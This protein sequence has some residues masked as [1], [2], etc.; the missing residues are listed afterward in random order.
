M[1]NY[2]SCSKFADWVRGTPKPRA[3]TSEGWRSW[4][5]KSKSVYP[6]R[7]WVAEEG[8]DKVQN[9]VNL[10]PDTL[11]KIKYYI[12]NRWVSK[13]HALT[14]NLERGKWHEF[15]TRL[16]H[17]MFDEL[18]NFV[19]IEQAWSHIAWDSDARKKHKPPFYA[20][21][22]FR[23]RVWRSRDAAME[24]LNWAASLTIES[25]DHENHGKPTPQALNAIETLELYK[26]WKE[27]R[28]NRVDPHV[29][30][31]WSAIC[32]RQSDDDILFPE[33]T[34]EEEQEVQKALNLSTQ[35]EEQ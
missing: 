22:W 13:T 7:Y 34:P 33:R 6:V 8:L 1:R 11:Y 16:L 26:W 29:A 19:E 2:W 35:I 31:G 20:S 18:V 30:S 14:S 15:D 23:W 27:V 10:I 17:C 28:P 5:K 3:E 4:N 24:Y 9:F 25:P 12:N 21:G 32:E